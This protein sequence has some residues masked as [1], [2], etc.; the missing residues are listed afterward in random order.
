MAFGVYVH[1]PWCAV[2]CPYCDFAVS[3]ARPI[4]QA[5]YADAVL[6]ELALRAPAFEGRELASV[7]LGGGTP[8]LWEPDQVARV[9]A[10]AAARFGARPREVTLEANPESAADAGRLR[11][12]RDAGVNRLSVGVQ[13]FDAGVLV[14]LGRRHGPEQAERALRLAGE[15]F[16]DVAADLIYGARRSTVATAAADAARLAALPVTHVSAYALTLDPEIMAE[17]VPFARMRRE[18]R[19]PLPGDEEVLA[20]ARAIR[21]GLRRGGLRRYE[22][23]N[24]ARPGREAV[25]NRLYWVGESYLGLGAGAVGALLRPGQG[26]VRWSNHRGPE[27][28]LAAVEAGRAPSAEEEPLDPAAVERERLMLGLRLREGVPLSLVPEARRRELEPLRRGRLAVLGGGRVRLTSRGLDL[29]SAIAERL[30]P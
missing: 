20:Q 24:F 18:G 9:V 14:K 23:S 11:A 2:H 16:E 29:H 6:A 19:L 5:R 3:T 27:T 21:A 1:F 25:H 4:P 15:V 30:L 8:S 12:Y 10:G 22:I 17:E 13:S 26:G 28:Y 7:Y